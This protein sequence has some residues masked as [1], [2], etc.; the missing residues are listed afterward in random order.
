MSLSLFPQPA[1]VRE[2]KNAQPRAASVHRPRPL[3]RSRTAPASSPNRPSFVIRSATP[4][5]GAEEASQVGGSKTPGST[6]ATLNTQLLTPTPSTRHSFDSDSEEVTIMVGR[7]QRSWK[8]SMEEPEWEIVS[9]PTRA[10][11]FQSHPSS[12]P[13]ETRADGQSKTE[14]LEA[15]PRSADMALQNESQATVGIARSVSVSRAGG[16][17]EL[18]K[19]TLVKAAT[20]DMS[21]RLV[22]HKPLT[23]TLV[24]LKNRKSQR[25]QLVDA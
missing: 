8:A 7:P 21:E 19:P 15:A 23:P 12:A 14:A 11:T 24:E 2:G 9:K 4:D 10:S 17:R 5:Q 18:L 1:G 6:D 20:T 22:D 3:Q 16:R 13:L 25:V